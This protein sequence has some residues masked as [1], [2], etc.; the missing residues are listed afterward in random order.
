MC[1]REKYLRIRQEE[2]EQTLLDN[3]DLIDSFKSLKVMKKVKNIQFKFIQPIGI[4][5][6]Y[7]KIVKFLNLN[8]EQDKEGLVSCDL[9]NKYFSKDKF[10]SGIMKSENYMI[11]AHPYFRRSYSEFSNFSPHFIALFWGLNCYKIDAYIAIDFN[12]VRIDMDGGY[13]M[14]CDTWFGSPFNKKIENISD[15]VAKLK[16]PIVDKEDGLLFS[17]IDDLFSNVY[18]LDIMW[19]TTKDNIKVFQ[20]EEFKNSS[21]IIEVN[22]I[23]YYPVRYIHAEFDI[24]NGYFRH[25]DGAVQL[26]TKE[27]YE[28]R[29]DKNFNYKVKGKEQ[30]KPNSIKLFKMNG[31]VSIEIWI[32]FIS[33]FFSGNPLVMEYFLGEY[34]EHVSDALVKL[35]GIKI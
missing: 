28:L 15:G 5:A 33:H 3:S 25:F 10:A 11:M 30:I 18:S 32:E 13:Y 27:E 26:Y 16:P 29:K 12:R 21:I 7:P 2:E 20:A 19:Y 31:E 9:L 35:K 6:I 14:E 24:R 23:N 8:I 1:S 22:G 17:I 4:V 34:P